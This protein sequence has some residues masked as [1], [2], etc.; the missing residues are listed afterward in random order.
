MLKI[1]RF[2]AYP[3]QWHMLTR[4][5]PIKRGRIARSSRTS[6]RNCDGRSDAARFL[7]AAT[8]KQR[9]AKSCGPGAAT[10]ASIRAGPCWHG[11]G[12]KKRRSPGRARIS[13]QTIARGKPGCLGCTCLIRVRFSLPIAHG[14][15]GAVGARL[16]LRPLI[17]EGQRDSEL[18]R[19]HVV[20]TRRLFEKL[21]QQTHCRPGQ[22]KRDPGPITTGRGLATAGAPAVFRNSTLWLWVPAFAGT[23]SVYEA[24][25]A[26]QIAS[27]RACSAALRIAAIFAL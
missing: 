6:G 14:A 4:S 25:R 11:N 23:T 8:A 7:R 2:S 13:R 1:F 3:N 9:T 19:N 16:S 18:R 24:I 5:G 26:T 27:P 21:N 10:V 22:A 15:A 17:G 20:R 12:D